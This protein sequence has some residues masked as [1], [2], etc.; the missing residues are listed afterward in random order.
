MEIK[1]GQTVADDFFKGLDFWR[2]A[3]GRADAPA[4]LIYAGD[5][6]FHTKGTNVISWWN[7]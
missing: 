6:S 1:S 5:R 3:S 4:A 2:N 7:F